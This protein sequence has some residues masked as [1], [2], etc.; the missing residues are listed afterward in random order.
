MKKEEKIIK[1]YFGDE[2]KDINQSEFIQV[3]PLTL[4]DMLLEYKDCSTK[5]SIRRKTIERQLNDKYECYILIA[6]KEEFGKTDFYLNASI[7]DV[8]SMFQ[9]AFEIYPKFKDVVKNIIS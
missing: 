4:I 6:Q 7:L 8:I 1:K 2:I 5:T 3:L 9:R